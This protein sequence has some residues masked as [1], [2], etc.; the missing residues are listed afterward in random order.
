MT[1]HTPAFKVGPPLDSLATTSV[2]KLIAPDC[3][4]ENFYAIDPGLSDLLD[5]YMKED[6][7]AHL[8]PH[9]QDLGQVAGNRL[10]DLAITADKERNKPVLRTRNRFGVE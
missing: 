5:L 6:A 1:L 2:E 4:G 10:N 9:L 8:E 7:R 3:H